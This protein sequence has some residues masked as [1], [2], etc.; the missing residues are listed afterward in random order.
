MKLLFTLFLMLSLVSELTASDLLLGMPFGADLYLHKTGFSLGYSNKKRQAIWVAYIL[1]A[2]NLQTKQFARKDRFNVDPAIKFFPVYPK[3]YAKS[4]FDKGHLAPAA[5]M[6]YSIKSMNNSFLMTNISPQIP[7]CNRG[8]WK[9]LESKVRLWAK[10][11]KRLYVITGPVFSDTPSMLGK[12]KIPVPVAFFKVVFDLTP[13]HKMAAFIVPNHTTKRQLES[14]AVSV[15]TVELLTGLDF[16]CELDDV[17]E[18]KL[19]KE[20]NFK[21]WL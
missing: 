7:G 2:D 12:T 6:T 13:P 1:S 10:R 14:F 8:I 21:S 5:D 9:R 16:F 15:D 3:D 11:E 18:N 4:G 19:E 20:I 17:L